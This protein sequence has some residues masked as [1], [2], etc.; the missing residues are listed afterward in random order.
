[1]K[2]AF[3]TV[4]LC[5]SSAAAFA[6]ILNVASVEKV[7]MPENSAV[8]VAGISPQGDYILVT[9]VQNKGLSKYDLATGKTTVLTTAPGAGY[10]AQISADGQNIVYRETSFTKDD[11][12]MNTLKKQNLATGEIATLVAATRDLQ[13]VA[14]ENGAAVAV[15]KGK[16]AVKALGAAKAKVN[17]PVL[18]IKNRQLMM[19]VNGKTRV[20]SPNGTGV[21]YIWPSL[22]P[23]ET[24]VLY[25]VCGNGAY[26]CNI[27][28]SNVK[29][30]GHFT[31]PKWYNDEVVVAMNDKDNGDFVT[32]SEIVAIDLDGNTQTLTD[33]SVI[34][35]YPYAS[36]QGDKIAFSTPAGEAYIININVKK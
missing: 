11:L 3:F 16:V 14:I 6:Q 8:A 28:G 7:A 21:S 18:S 17:A 33:S 23:D 5:L 15:N 26:T 36:A 20:F 24:K 27:D 19:T 9:D 35:M 22:S 13:G 30:L 10:A 1:M 2:K 34:A 29:Y 31:S 25:Y 32:S 4:A 12:R